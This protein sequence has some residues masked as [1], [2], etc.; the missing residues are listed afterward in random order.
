MSGSQM[1]C[2]LAAAQR[3]SLIKNR[4]KVGRGT[5]AVVTA[6]V[7]AVGIFRRVR[8]QGLVSLTGSY[9]I[10]YVWADVRVM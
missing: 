3:N 6:A 8:G 10:F 2:A 7:R 9:V 5:A 1:A 4:E